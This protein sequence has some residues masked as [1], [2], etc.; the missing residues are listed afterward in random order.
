MEIFRSVCYLM[1]LRQESG[2]AIK[3]ATKVF[4][5]WWL[6]AYFPLCYEI[7]K[8]NIRLWDFVDISRL[9]TLPC[10]LCATLCFVYSAILCFCKVPMI[11]GD[12]NL[13]VSCFLLL[14]SSSQD[15][16]AKLKIPPADTRYQT[17]V[18]FF[19]QIFTCLQ[20]RWL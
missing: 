14:L 16:K 5:T 6:L 4:L 8:R 9:I 15:W 18:G 10:I 20:S 11:V 2:L 13:M 7:C 17:E 3:W 12:W 19:N 1:G